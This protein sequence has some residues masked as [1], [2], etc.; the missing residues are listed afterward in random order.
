MHKKFCGLYIEYIFEY[1]IETLKEK[2]DYHFDSEKL[3]YVKEII[4]KEIFQRVFKSLLYCMN[5]ER[6]DGNLYGNTS[7]ERYEM[8]SNTR[9]CIEAMSKNFPTMRD[10]I[11]D[12]MARKCVYVMEVINELENN[13]N[14]IGRYFGI[15]PEEIVQ[16]QNSGDWHD[17]ECVLIFTFKSQDKI[18]Y[19]PTRG[20]NL[21]FMK[22]FMDY[23]FE[24]EYAEQY[25]GLCIR[26]GIWVKFV[27]HIELTNPR[28]VEQFY[29]NYGKVLFV[30]YI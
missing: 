27:K 22:G 13:K 30:A 19:K 6:L 21:Q 1:I 10:Q 23:F 4:E 26:E 18:V 17:S 2:E 28:K 29:Y 25:I 12:E 8:F 16:V 3:E 15:T 11:Y 24:P 20:E 14:K 5:V 9:Y 7:E